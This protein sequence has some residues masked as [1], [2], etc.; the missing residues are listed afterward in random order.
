MDERKKPRAR[1]QRPRPA[2]VVGKL[3]AEEMAALQQMIAEVQA[4]RLRLREAIARG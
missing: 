4:E 3:S 2:A 1:R